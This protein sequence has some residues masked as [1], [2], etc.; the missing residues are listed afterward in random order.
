MS[1]RTAPDQLAERI[2]H[3]VARREREIREFIARLVA[4]PTENPPGRNYRECARLLAARI[5]E[6]GLPVE[7]LRVPSTPARREGTSKSAPA[8]PRFCVLSSFGRGGRTL[9]FQGHYD[10]VPAQ[11]PQQF[12]PV[13]KNG[14]L[15]GRGSADM[16]SGLAAMV[17]AMAVLKALDL[18]LDGNIRLMLVPD[19]ETGGAGGT[20]YLAESGRLGRN[21]IGMLTPEPTSGVIWNA[22]RGAIS[23]RVIVRG[24]PAHV[25]LHYR[26]VNA[27]E[28]G[29]QVA[30]AFARLKRRVA[31]RQTRFAITPA[32]ARRSVLLI[33]G[34][35]GGGTNFNAVPAEFSFTLDRRINPEESLHREKRALL[36]VV[37]QFR[38]RGMQ[39]E[40]QIFQEEPAAGFSS[41]EPVARA[42]AESA[43]EI[44]GRAPRF[45]MC[46][47]LLETR[48][49][50]QCGVPAF[51]FGPGRL[52]VAHG[53]V[54]SVAL[55]KVY[56]FTAIYAL[57]SARILARN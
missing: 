38:S 22:C 54:E 52:E 42:L 8:E 41:Q 2:R 36:E 47:G 35:S 7:T 31:A 14:A 50:A 4:I 24:R 13:V 46:P 40:A 30:D 10:V 45:E 44:L 29:M 51:A 1:R 20:R 6:L 34:E 32:A 33:G 39:V 43:R 57:A 12:R 9:F 53:P 21:G 5:R 27:F 16:K 55:K 19:E 48:Y 15:C 18:P 49:Y 17:Y 56:E 37:H 23:V 3:A 11:S 25:G 28:C 26:G